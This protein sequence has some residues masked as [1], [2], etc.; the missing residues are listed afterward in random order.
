MSNSVLNL[1]LK[2]TELLCEFFKRE[3]KPPVRV[4]KGTLET[5][6][7]VLNDVFNT[8]E[9]KKKIFRAIEL[10]KEKNYTEIEILKKSI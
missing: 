8:E 6:N 2:D 10:M 4:S 3:G 1:N 9:R 5:F 7:T